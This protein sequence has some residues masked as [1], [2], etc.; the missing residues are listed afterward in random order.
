MRNIKVL[1]TEWSDGWGGQEIRIIQEMEGIREK[2]IDVRIACRKESAIYQK[3]KELNFI[4]YEAP[5]TSKFD[6]KSL[7]LLRKIIKNE[8]IDI[9]NTH[10]GIDSWIG[11]F[12]AYFLNVK[13]I[14]TRHL[15]I[16]ISS[17]RT[18][19][20]NEIADYIIT[21]GESVKENMIKNNRIKIDRIESI[22][23]GID[24]TVFEPL[25]YNKIEM[26]K[27]YGISLDKKVVGI[28][29]VLRGFKRHDIFVDV[30]KEFP[31]MEFVI[32]GDGPQKDNIKKWIK[33][34]KIKNIK[35]IG[36]ISKPEEFLSAI[37]IQLLTSGSGEGVPQTLI[38]GLMMNKD[39]ISTNV[40]SIKDLWFENNFIMIDVKTDLFI[41]NLKRLFNNEIVISKNRE[42]IVENFSK[43]AMVNK[44][45]N[46]YKRLLK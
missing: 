24:D 1:H 9:V 13:F 17:S 15:S 18:N 22:A 20:I 33:E 26:R 27:K 8:K 21:T 4:T 37:D 38:Q 44:I 43:T 7:F 28:L 31:Q 41:E 16:P 3:A 45:L 14:R 35:I 2:G 11:G 6:F 32:A 30:A 23:T 12:A 29:A 40:G 10:S 42:Y 25:K 34:K 39:I 36:H 46:I 5:F 19:F